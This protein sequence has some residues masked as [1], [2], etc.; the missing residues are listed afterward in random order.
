M[1]KLNIRKALFWDIDF[2]R[3]NKNSNKNLVIERVFCY[4]TIEE[5]KNIFSYYGIETIKKEIQNTGFLDNK[6]LEFA[7]TLLNIPRTKFKCYKKKQ[8][9]PTHWN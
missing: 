4:G 1:E 6:T 8:S 3:F 5:L 9:A 7:S 2:E